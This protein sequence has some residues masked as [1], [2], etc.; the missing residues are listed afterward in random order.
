LT[1]DHKMVMVSIF[2][3]LMAAIIIFIATVL[4][5]GGIAFDLVKGYVLPLVISAFTL[6]VFWGVLLL[7][8]KGKV[9][10]LGSPEPANVMETRTTS[11]STDKPEQ[12]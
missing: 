12:A 6:T 2:S 10:F 11:K 8:N 4:V 7:R 9:P 5:S 1:E 3:T